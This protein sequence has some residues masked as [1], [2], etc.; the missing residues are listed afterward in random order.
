MRAHA[1][2]RRLA[3]E[4]VDV[5]RIQ[6]A[7][8][9]SRIYRVQCGSRSY[10]LKQYPSKEFDRRDRLATE[11]GALRLMEHS[12]FDTVPRVIAVDTVEGY[13]LLSW[14]E[15]T[16]V[17][18]LADTDIDSAVAFLAATH[19]M[20]FAPGAVEQPAAAEACLSAA[21]LDRQLSARRTRLEGLV[22]SEPELFALLKESFDPA[23]QHLLARAKAGLAVARLD[24]ATE[25]PHQWRTLVPS[26][27][28]FHNSLRCSD[29]SLAFLDFEYF[30]WDDP[31]K[32]TA[33]L[34]L[35]P[36]HPLA[37][38]HRRRFRQSA[39]ALYGEDPAFATRL[40]ALLPLYGLRWV[41]IMLNEFIPE[42]WQNRVL[43]GTTESWSEAKSR[44]I[45]HARDY[46]ASLAGK[47]ES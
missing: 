30:G 28:G 1:V 29:G 11:V 6:S 36:G 37:A 33:D 39:L 3:G 42:R 31:V 5:Q 22:A 43:A 26:D 40:I 23:Y 9:N 15:G 13:A 27:F 10:A 46:L 19:A 18:G 32:M 41:L 38:T 20:R 12:K 35:H 17:T 47:V 7:G 34:L 14:I 24:F 21:E 4:S 45:T 25:L 16:E 8:R 44:Q 2:A